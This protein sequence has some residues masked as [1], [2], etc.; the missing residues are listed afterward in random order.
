VTEGVFVGC[1]CALFARSTE[2][3]A[4]AAARWLGRAEQQSAEEAAA[5]G[6]LSGI[7]DFEIDGP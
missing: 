3:A 4:L 7:A 1:P 2:W 6:M 5:S